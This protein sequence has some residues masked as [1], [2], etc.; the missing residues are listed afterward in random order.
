MCDIPH[1]PLE[2]LQHQGKY[3][4]MSNEKNEM[5][6]KVKIRKVRWTDKKI[7]DQRIHF[8]NIKQNIQHAHID[9]PH[10]PLEYLQHQGKYM[11]M[12]NEK[13]EKSDKVKIRKVRWTDKKIVV[14]RI[15]FVNTKQN[16]QHA[17]Q[18]RTSCVLKLGEVGFP[19]VEPTG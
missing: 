1:L 5:S 14:Q 17:Q 2:Y 3:M 11:Y 15:H 10:L 19:M 7:V 16:I 6:D 4:Y 18:I 9:L 8:V 13:N 12:S